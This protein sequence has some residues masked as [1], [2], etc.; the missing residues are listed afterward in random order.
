MSMQA[1]CGKFNVQVIIG[2]M[3]VATFWW[4]GGDDIPTQRGHEL[5]T[6]LTAIIIG[7]LG[8]AS[9]AYLL[10]AVLGSLSR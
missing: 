7:S 10:S 2:A 5:I 3:V 9:A 6:F 1:F 8:W 4:L